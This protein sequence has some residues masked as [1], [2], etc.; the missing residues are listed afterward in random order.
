MFGPVIPERCSSLLSALRLNK[1]L[2]IKKGFAST[3]SLLPK[4]QSASE[5]VKHKIE[6]V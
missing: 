3:A 4:S 1:I 5:Y 2:I 6:Y